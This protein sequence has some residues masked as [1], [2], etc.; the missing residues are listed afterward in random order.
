MKLCYG[1]VHIHTINSFLQCFYYAYN[2]RV[3]EVFILDHTV[4]NIV[5]FIFI[6]VRSQLNQ[7][8]NYSYYYE[9]AYKYCY[10]VTKKCFMCSVV[11]ISVTNI[12]ANLRSSSHQIVALPF[13][14]IVA[15]QMINTLK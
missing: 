7:D 2:F 4:D 11:G 5:H 15:N 6:R 8:N 9:C 12:I 13:S 10:K 3:S 14:G 1:F